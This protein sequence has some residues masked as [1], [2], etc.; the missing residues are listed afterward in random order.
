MRTGGRGAGTV[1]RTQRREGSGET[2]LL[3]LRVEHS[4]ESRNW[5]DLEAREG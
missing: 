4:A 1:G 5:G 2:V 3:A